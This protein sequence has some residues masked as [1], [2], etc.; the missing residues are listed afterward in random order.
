M[1]ADGIRRGDQVTVDFGPDGWHQHF[2]P[3]AHADEDSACL[4][5][6]GFIDVLVATFHFAEAP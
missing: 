6:I 3:Q 5:A 2:L 1:K 4:A